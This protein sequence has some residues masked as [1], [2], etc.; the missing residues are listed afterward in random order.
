MISF[1]EAQTEEEEELDGTEQS[2]QT[3]QRSI[4]VVLLCLSESL[5]W[6]WF[7]K[8]TS[9]KQV[10]FLK[11]Q[12]SKE[13]V[14]VPPGLSANICKCIS[15]VSYLY[16]TPHRR[17]CRCSVGAAPYLFAPP[18]CA[19]S[20]VHTV[21]SFAAG[22]AKQQ[23]RSWNCLSLVCTRTKTHDVHIHMICVSARYDN[24]APLLVT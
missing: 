1:S 17:E 19:V 14:P 8:A 18:R 20:L 11:T 21:W 10:V 16:I 15:D 3:T 6:T 7:G 23:Q 12:L 13:K 5:Q 9:K 24:V 4:T 22:S 2:R